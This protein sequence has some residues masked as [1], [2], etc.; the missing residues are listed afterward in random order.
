[1]TATAYLKTYWILAEQELCFLLSFLLV[2]HQIYLFGRSL[3]QPGATQDLQL[4]EEQMLFQPMVIYG[5]FQESLR[6]Y[7]EAHPEAT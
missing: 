5:I 1:M 6:R 4:T 3:T 2:H 7:C